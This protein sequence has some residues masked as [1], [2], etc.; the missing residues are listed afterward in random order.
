M[1]GKMKVNRFI[2]PLKM[3]YQEEDIPQIGANEVL[4]KVK[5]SDEAVAKRFFTLTVR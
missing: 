1:T 4:I 3:V 2:E 5:D